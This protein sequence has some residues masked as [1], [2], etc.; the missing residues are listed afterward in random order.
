MDN[1]LSISLL[2][3]E[4]NDTVAIEENGKSVEEED[5]N[6]KFNDCSNIICPIGT[7]YNHDQCGNKYAYPLYFLSVLS[8]LSLVYYT[9]SIIMAAKQTIQKAEDQGYVTQE[10]I[11]YYKKE[12][13]HLDMI[14]QSVFVG[15]NIAATL[16][17]YFL[18]KNKTS[19]P[20]NKSEKVP[21]NVIARCIFPTATVYYHEENKINKKTV[22]ASLCGSLYTFF[23]YKPTYQEKQEREERSNAI[24]V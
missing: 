23:F 4:S 16:I 5:S 24:T 12:E 20:K 11:D 15:I 13:R 19:N 10:I 7:A 18:Y 22:L 9:T 21:P 6:L 14:Y 1:K 17:F 2:A 8:I 3:P